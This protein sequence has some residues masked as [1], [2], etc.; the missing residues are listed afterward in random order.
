MTSI[1]C[2]CA[3][4]SCNKIGTKKCA[5]CFV[6]LYCSIECQKADWKMHKLICSYEKESNKLLPF[7]TVDATI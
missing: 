2:A 7:P 3:Y 5:G 4:P 1:Q 6:E